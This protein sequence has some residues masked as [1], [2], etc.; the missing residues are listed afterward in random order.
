[1]AKTNKHSKDDGKQISEFFRD[2]PEDERREMLGIWNQS[3]IIHHEANAN[4]ISEEETEDALSALHAKLGF[5]DEHQQ[6]YSD[7]SQKKVGTGRWLYYLA[8]AAVLMIALGL[9]L[10]TPVTHTIPAGQT[11]V[12][13]LR[14]GSSISA[15]SGTFV[16]YSRIFGFSNRTVQIDGEAFFEVNPGETPFIVKANGSVAEVLGTSFNVRSW[17]TDP[18]T[19]TRIDVASGI[20]K[21]FAESRPGDAVHLTEGYGSF[22][23]ELHP[24]PQD[25]VTIQLSHAL[26]WRDN[27]LA[28]SVQP[29][30]VIFNELERKYDVTIEWSD[31]EIAQ[32]TLSTFYTQPDNVESVLADICTVKGLNYSRTSTG[33]RITR[34]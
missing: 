17:S 23:S 15:N 27:N 33:Y 19:E 14:D 25:P 7:S 34:N 4:E 28:F 21:F 32:T 3:G 6:D 31:A 11:A 5:D 8:A 2:L 26:A 24:V 22:V 18:E 12:I 30:S 10:S 20:V 13:D 29:L 16:A 9:W 1:M